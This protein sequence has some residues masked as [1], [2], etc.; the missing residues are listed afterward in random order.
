M[1]RREDVRKTVGGIM[2]DDPYDWLQRESDEA[3]AWQKR[4]VEDAVTTARSV[5]FYQRLVDRIRHSHSGSNAAMLTGAGPRLVGGRWFRIDRNDAGTAEV[6]R[7]ADSRDGLGHVVVDTA[8]LSAQRADGLV[9]SLAYLEPSP[10]GR[11]VAFGTVTGGDMTGVLHV[12]DVDSGHLLD[13]EVPVLFFN[14]PRPEWLPDGSGFFL[15]ERGADARHQVRFVPVDDAAPDIP[16]AV[17]DFADVPSTLPALLVQVSPSGRHVV[18]VTAPHEHVAAVGGEVGGDWGRFSPDGFAGELH[19]D[20]LDDDTYVAIVTDTPR[21]RVVAIPYATSTDPNTWRELVPASDLVLRALQVVDG[22]LVVSSL[23]DVALDVRVYHGDGTLV[24]KA[25][26]PPF[27]GSFG[28]V[29]PGRVKARSDAFVFAVSTLTSS[30]VT[31]ELDVATARLDEVTPPDERLEHVDVQRRFAT[32]RD[33]T[34]IPYFTV[35]SDELDLTSPQPTLVDAYGGFNAPWIPSFTPQLPPFV[36]SG[37]VYVR[38]CLRGGSEYGQDWYHAGRRHSKQHVFDDLR[39]VAEDLVAR[40][41][42][43]PETLAFE[44]ASNGGLLAGVAVTQQA[45]LWRVVVPVVPLF[46]MLEPLADVPGADAIRSYY[47]EDYGDPDVPADA[48]VMQAYSP[49]H[50]VVEAT[51]Y[52]AVFCVFGEKDLSCPPFHGRKFTAALQH[53]TTSGHP[54]CLRV[55]DD[56]GHGSADPDIAAQ[57]AAEWL[58][59]VMRELGMTLADPVFMS[60]EHVR[61]VNRQLANADPVRRA[62][63]DLDRSYTVGY[64]LHQGPGSAVVH[65]AIVFDPVDG[66]RMELAKTEAPDLTYVGDWARVVRASAAGRRGKQLDPGVETRGD[67][68]VLDT[69]GAA[70]AAAQ[71]VATVDVRFPDVPGE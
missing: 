69:V 63:A 29:G 41:Q 67:V 5:P 54:V 19:G 23:D 11:L 28:L 4:Q 18:A 35:A 16:V 61:I 7:V 50:N 31:Y 20:W 66:V 15:A 10:D 40:G 26:L 44:G 6:V 17:F 27:S 43:L 25:A 59:F 12:A 55:W 70:F 48:A 49:Y 51:P 13:V 60:R 52:P 2:F 1:T 45:D 64:E 56:V 53:A 46:D 65:W 58:A 68:G 71:E 9:V 57:L 8:E 24:G 22:R 21:G 33:G 38:A 30:D 36:E 39:A 3:L 14:M 42:A 34:R 47:T 37:G 32:S 62:C